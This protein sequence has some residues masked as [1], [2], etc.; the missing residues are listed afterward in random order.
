MHVK[1][2]GIINYQ[3]IEKMNLN[4]HVIKPWW[5]LYG[6][7]ISEFGKD[8]ELWLHLQRESCHIRIPM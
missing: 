8:L 2:N 5:S 1:L 7:I 4:L 6:N 3:R